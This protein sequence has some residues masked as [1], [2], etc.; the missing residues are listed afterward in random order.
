MT[1]N[2]SCC[3]TC[4]PNCEDVDC[5]RHTQREAKE[6]RALINRCSRVEGQIRGIKGMLDKNAYCDDILHQIAAAQSALDALSRV[7]LERHMNTCLITRIQAGETEVVD[8]L[9][10]TIKKLMR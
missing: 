3:T 4:D 8:E 2:S 10:T 9:I 1:T 5:G 6:I 7:V